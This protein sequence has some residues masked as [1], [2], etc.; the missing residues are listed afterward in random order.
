MASGN[1]SFDAQVIVERVKEKSDNGELNASYFVTAIIVIFI[2]FYALGKAS[3]MADYFS[4]LDRR[5]R[6]R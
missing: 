3:K 4:G 5:N 2:A 6:Y 1:N